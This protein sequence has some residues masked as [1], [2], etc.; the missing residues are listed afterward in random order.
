MRKVSSKVLRL[1]P[2][3]YMILVLS[4]YF[5]FTT[6]GFFDVSNL[7]NILNQSATLL[8]L[9]CGQTII[10]LNDERWKGV[11]SPQ[12]MSIDYAVIAPGFHGKID[13]IRQIFDIREIILAHNLPYFQR[14]ALQEECRRLRI[15]CHCVRT[16]GAFVAPSTTRL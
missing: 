5:G 9:A 3:I 14:K 16:D 15:R 1:P 7:T 13:P 11:A 6:T 8:L 12:R 4:L 10:V 2:A